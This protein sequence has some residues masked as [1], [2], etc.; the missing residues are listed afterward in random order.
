M[1][2][3]MRT[4]RSIISISLF[5]TALFLSSPA[6]AVY[7][8]TNLV[9]SVP[10]LAALT[11]P[12]V[13]NPWGLS[14]SATSPWWLANNGSS[15]ATLYNA[16]TGTEPS[17]P[18]PVAIPGGAPTGTVFNG[19]AALF[20]LSSG[21]SGRFIFATEAGTI[22]GWNSGAS[23]TTAFTAA[24]GA[25]YKGL[26][27][28]T[29]GA[30]T[31][32]YATD[33]HNGKIDVINSSFALVTLAG[34]PFVDP[35]IP[36]GYAPFGIQNINGKLYVTYALQDADKKDEIDLA[37]AG[38]VAEFNTDGTFVAH[39]A[40]GGTLNAPWG[41]ALAP[42]NFGEFGND[43]L[44]GNFGDGRINAYDPTTDA[45][46]GQ[47]RTATG[48][49]TIDGLWAIAFG[50]GIGASS[51]PSNALFFT[52]GIN[53]EDDGLFGEITV[54]EPSSL[55]MLAMGLVGLLGFGRSHM[56]TRK[57]TTA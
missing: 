11:D 7:V 9:S 10:G 19:N 52:A 26:T 53:G 45:F 6:A 18:G 30:N 46:L 23:A 56:R 27:I 35:A 40:V 49:L 33:F 34:S 57:T 29:S 44:V 1:E 16:T 32:L 48:P 47:L 5:G 39:I 12:N 8:E 42:L 24:D 31:F 43:L 22:A 4:S 37:G 28:G 54:P 50:G 17:P 13:V 14:R 38:Y 36:A 25:I 15:T 2:S 55:A 3:H 21:G 41:L 51:G 20:P